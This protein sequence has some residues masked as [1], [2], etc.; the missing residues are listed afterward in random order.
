MGPTPH[1]GE[2]DAQITSALSQQA[3]DNVLAQ[4]SVLFQLGY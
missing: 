1:I 2:T 3:S 4:P